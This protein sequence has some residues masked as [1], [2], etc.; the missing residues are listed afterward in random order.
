MTT[1]KKK[2]TKQNKTKKNTSFGLKPFEAEFS[3]KLSAKELQVS[4]KRKKKN[5]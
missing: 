3:K 5:L 4:N 1:V 2:N